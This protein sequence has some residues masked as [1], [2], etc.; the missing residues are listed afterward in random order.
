MDNKTN[1]RSS[2]GASLE[3]PIEAS[4][5][6][7]LIV[8]ELSDALARAGI[9][10]EEGPNGK[11]VQS[12]FEVGRV[13]FWKPGD[14]IG[15]RWRAAD[16]LPDES[17]EVKVRF[18]KFDGGTRVGFEYRGLDRLVGEPGE[19][20]GWFASEVAAPFLQA[21][22]PARFG[23]W[24][25]DRRARRPSGAQARSIYRDPLYHYPNFRVILA[26]LALT[27]EDYLLE[28]GCGGGALLKQAL[29][30]GCRAAAVDHSAEMG[31]LGQGKNCDSVAEGRVGVKKSKRRGVA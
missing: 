24:V 14:E 21:L 2:I 30:S 10:F 1:D 22:S 11:V 27:R 16:W 25:T 18:E 5:A 6:F 12:G 29:E 26:E 8:R 15:L 20:A 13:L 28:V 19:A 4:V 7:D 17:S 9:D 31:R 3:V 23:D